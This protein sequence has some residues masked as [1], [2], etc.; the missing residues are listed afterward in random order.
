M[1]AWRAWRPAG[2]AEE[3]RRPVEQSGRR[4]TTTP[5]AGMPGASGNDGEDVAS[6]EDEVLVSAVLH[7]GAAVLAVDDLVAHRDV[8][9]DAVAVVVDAAGTDGLDLALLGLLLG[10]VGDDQPGGGGLLRLERLDDDP[11]LE[12]LDVDRHV[13]STSTFSTVFGLG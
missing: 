1:D 11:V 4:P 7:L 5:P 12:R 2:E 10:R 9:R 8:E 3:G 6:G 13:V